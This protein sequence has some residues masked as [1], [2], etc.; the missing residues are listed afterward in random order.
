MQPQNPRVP[1]SEEAEELT[2]FLTGAEEG[3][4]TAGSRMM[5]VGLSSGLFLFPH[6]FFSPSPFPSR[7]LLGHTGTRAHLVLLE[8]K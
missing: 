2:V 4:H 8:L 6:L 5:Q 1:L 3:V 7:V